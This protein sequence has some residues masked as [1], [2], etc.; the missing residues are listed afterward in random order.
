MS[1]VT[2]VQSLAVQIGLRVRE[3]RIRRR[4]S[5]HDLASK[6]GVSERTVRKVEKGDTSVGF[7][8]VLAACVLLD[9]DFE[10]VV[11]KATASKRAPRRP[12]EI[13]ASETDF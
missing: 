2:E 12:P 5:T 8:T 4:F 7:G 3:A 6:L 13:A 1:L 9:V 11:D 10:R